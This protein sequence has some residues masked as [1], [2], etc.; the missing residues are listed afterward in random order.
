MNHGVIVL[1]VQTLYHIND[2]FVDLSIN[3]FILFFAE[4]CYCILNIANLERI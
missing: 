1:A 4:F 3:Q 2:T